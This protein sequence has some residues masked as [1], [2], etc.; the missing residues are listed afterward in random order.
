MRNLSNPILFIVSTHTMIEVLNVAENMFSLRKKILIIF[1]GALESDSF[2]VSLEL[3]FFLGV[4][5]DS[6]DSSEFR[7]TEQIGNR[8]LENDSG[9]F[10]PS[11]QSENNAAGVWRRRD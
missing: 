5:R 2:L 9:F 10:F 1:I 3:K 7:K 6:R 4:P 8:C 11:R